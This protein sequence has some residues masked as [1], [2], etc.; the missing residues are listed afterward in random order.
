LEKSLSDYIGLSKNIDDLKYDKKLKVA[1]LSSF[2][3]NGLNETL[4]VKCSE[5]GIR[6]QSYLGGYNQ[7]NQ[8]LLNSESKLYN[9]S[10][11][12]IFLIID[13]RN[14]FGDSFHNAHN[15]SDDERKILAK[16]KI[17]EL[18]NLIQTFENNSNSKLI[19]TNLNVPSYSPNGIIESKL[20]FGF[21][22][23]IEEIN[24]SLRQ[25]SKNHGSVYVYD[26]RQFISKFGEQNIFDYRQF[27]LGDIQITFNF[28]PYFA[29]DLMNYIKPISGSNRKCI[30]LDL[31][32]TLWGGIVGE[33]G[34]DGIELGDT[35]NGK[36]FVEFQKELLSLWNQGII[37]AINSKN[38]VEDAMK[39]IS[40]HPNMVLREKNFANIQINWDDKAINFKKIA[41]EIN[42]GLNSIVFFDDDKINCERIK[43]E[44][45]EVLTIN[46]PNDPSQFSPILKELNDFHVLN[47]TDEDKKRGEMYAQQRERNKF[48]KSVSNLDDF[49]KD[50]DIRVNIK[51]SNDYLIPRISQLTLKTNQFNLT[52]KRYQEEEI[53]NLANDKKFTV[54]CA[55]VLD[56]FGDNGIT[57]VFIIDKNA[58]FWVIDTFLLSCRIMGRGVENA[59]LSQ[60]LKDAKDEGVDEVKAQFIPTPKNKPAENFLSDYGFEKEENFWIY[61]LNSE[62]KTPNHLKVETE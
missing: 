59:I 37:L 58:K 47:R 23:M 13:T 19:I 39:V 46:L 57:G 16:E 3:L 56:K 24:N 32:N 60:I 50:L 18:E 27:H 12:V 7:Y 61:K 34:F 36:A 8:E 62:I 30:V 41:D 14:V 38:N 55:Q 9:F 44:F 21:H 20:K 10:P 22:E 4:H 54:G 5:L 28:I 52:T 43:Q 45:P 51:K 6:Y 11:D 17:N 2:T 25:I 49:L 15:M 40:E 42:I 29:N 26:F 35:P 1:I 33:D 48:E 53:R 31:D